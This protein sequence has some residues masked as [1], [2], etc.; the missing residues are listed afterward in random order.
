LDIASRGSA[1]AV[2]A[3][4]QP[5]AVI[6]AAGF[7]RVDDAEVDPANC[8]RENVEGVRVLSDVCRRYNLPLLTFS[9]DLVFDGTKGEP[10]VESDAPLPLSE[11]GRS[12]FEA[13][14]VAAAQHPS[15]L[16]VRTAAFFGPWDRHNFVTRTMESLASGLEVH[17]AQDQV[18][19]PT[20]VPDLVHAS[21][22]LLLD[23]EH[24][25]WHI[26][27]GGD[28]T[29]SEFA[30]EIARRAALPR[31]LVVPGTSAELGAIA[32]RPAYTAL[33]SERCE[34]VPGL[35]SALTRYFEEQ[36]AVPFGAI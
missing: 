26:T 23:G 32:P 31:S 21:L 33:M 16:V 7:V 35:S 20:Y 17:V 1:S 3:R 28:V 10:Y 36:S 27:N 14:R 29:W 18:V 5:W 22:D 11:Y 12:K 9:S 25:I 2:I 19:S 8:Y 4:E 24:G 15:T 34:L 13:E 6:N 30:I